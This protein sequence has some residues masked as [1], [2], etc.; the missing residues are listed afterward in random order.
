MSRRSRRRKK[1]AQLTRAGSP[2]RVYRCVVLVAHH[3]R[4]AKRYAGLVQ[5]A[6][7]SALANRPLPKILTPQTRRQPRQ[8][9]LPDSP[10]TRVANLSCPTFEPRNLNAYHLDLPGNWLRVP[11]RDVTKRLT[12]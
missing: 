5:A 6:R 9:S 11:A 12:K 10:V 3:R 7:S 2:E 4:H 1:G 8:T